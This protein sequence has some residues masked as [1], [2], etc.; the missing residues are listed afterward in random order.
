MCIPPNNHFYQKDELREPNV[1]LT[2][3][4]RS[5][6]HLFQTYKQSLLRSGNVESNP[7]PR[8]QGDL[9]IITYN[10]RGLGDEKKLRHLLNQMHTRKGGKTRDFVACIQETYIT[11]PGKIPFLWRGNFHLTP[12]NGHSCGCL[13]ILSPHLNIVASRELDQRGHVIACQKAGDNKVIYIIANIYAPNANTADK[14]DFFEKV[15]DTVLELQESYNCNA[16]LVLGDFNLVLSEN[17]IK[18]RLYTS[19]ERRIASLVKNLL[20]TSDMKDVW[21]QKPSFTWRRAGTDVFSTIDRISY[22]A[23][24]ISLVNVEVNWSLGFSDHAAVEAIFKDC[25]IEKPQRS[26]IIRLDPHLAKV[27]WSRLKIEADFEEMFSSAPSHWDP[28]MKLDYAKLCIRTVVEQ[29]QAERKRKELNEEESL[30]EEL[31]TAVKLIANGTGHDQ[32]LGEIIEH[33]E[34]LRARKAVLIEEKG[35]R[36][37]ER[38]GSQWYNEGEK[39]TRYFLRLLNRSYPDDFKSIVGEHGTV[40]DPEAIELE[41]VKFYKNLYESYDKDALHVLEDNDEFFNELQSISGDAEQKIVDP[42][43]LR[44]LTATLRSCRDSSPGPDGIP[45]SILRIV[46]STYGPLLVEAWNHS[47]VTGKLP[48][49]HKLSYLKLIPKQGKDSSLLTNWRPITLS[50][51]DH[52]LITKTYSNRMCDNVASSI[53]GNQTAYIKGRLINDNIRAMLATVNVTNVVERA[54][55]ILVSL[56]A[57]KAFDSVEHSYIERCLKEFGC[58]RFIPIFKILYSDLSTNILIN[59]RIVKGFRILRGVKQGDALSCIIFIMCMEPLIRNLDNNPSIRPIRTT[60]IGTLPKVYAYAD[61]VSC[62]IADSIESLQQ[63]FNEYEKLSQ[64]SGL[65]L[66]ADKT[67]IMRLGSNNECQYNVTYQNQQFAI[68]TKEKVKING[69]IFQRSYTDLINE[70]SKVAAGRMDK[71]FKMWSRRGLSTLGRILII[72]TFGISQLIFMM[73]SVVFDNSHY[74]LFNNLIFKFVWNRHYLAAKAPERIKREIMCKPIKLGGFGMLNLENLDQS[75]KIKSLGRTPTS[76]HPFITILAERTSLASYFEPS[77]AIDLDP[78]H[79]QSIKYLKTLREKTWDSPHV[80]RNRSVLAAVQNLAIKSVLSKAGSLSIPFFSLRVRGKR[81]IGDLTELELRSLTRYIE[82]KK[83]ALLTKAITMAPARMAAPLDLSDSVLTCKTFKA[84]DKCTS[85]E[86]RLALSDDS[87]ICE[88]KLGVTLTPAEAI[89]WGYK[90]SRLTSTRH[91][92][93]ILKIAHGEVYT[94]L[95]LHKYNLAE[96]NSCPRCDSPEDLR[97]K[98]LDCE[99]ITRIWR[100][101]NSFNNKLTTTDISRIDPANA[102]IG[103]FRDSNPTILTINAEILLRIQ[104]LKDNQEYLIHPKTFVISCLKTIVRNERNKEVKEAI[105]A[106]LQ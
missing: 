92:N 23:S 62:T 74:K 17:E 87:P 66:N 88:Y 72:K 90:L 94:K 13:T 78:F 16:A 73:Q 91:K 65:V 55:G 40:T 89:N 25:L 18:N 46:W 5:H 44:D 33:V 97:H 27:E 101:V 67:E 81:K 103:G 79:Q 85:K 48:D 31:D 42:I 21:N 41:I 83:V 105:E 75:L 84:L 70:N 64:R 11:N 106:L 37:A 2:N 43:E 58:S 47:L 20:S 4:F 10:V 45:Y 50:N 8:A 77:C 26:K 15:F 7:G 28:H 1:N 30:N 93:I 86:I 96:S 76:N 49:S 53:K 12:G 80:D 34:S 95:K 24:A 63:V 57:K 100:C 32:R 14:A 3:V 19:Q 69:I 102:A 61:D 22:S 36:L 71:F 39:S 35:A 9:H 98:F 6:N 104:Y 29:V 99:Y 60:T 82:P 56:D 54:K 59:G 68:D 38:S 51:C 52:K